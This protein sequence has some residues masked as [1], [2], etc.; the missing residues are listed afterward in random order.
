MK[1]TCSRCDTQHLVTAITRQLHNDSLPCKHCGE[2]MDL[3]QS[4]S[5]HGHGDAAD[6]IAGMVGEYIAK[7]AP[8]VVQAAPSIRFSPE[9]VL[10]ILTEVVGE[11]AEDS[12][13]ISCS[14]ED[15][16]PNVIPMDLGEVLGELA[17]ETGDDEQWALDLLAEAMGE[18]PAGSGQDEGS[19]TTLPGGM[20]PVPEVTMEL[21]DLDIE[22]AWALQLLEPEDQL[23]VCKALLQ[24][25]R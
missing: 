13:A 23:A 7:S 24:N 22:D 3:D 20:P 25:P 1:I 2:N 17:S 16:A 14:A 5:A 19:P 10:P 9:R 18:A 4:P 6:S 11:P 15:D 12:L 8:A 21:Q